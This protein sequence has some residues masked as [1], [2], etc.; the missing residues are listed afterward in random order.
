MVCD[1]PPTQDAIAHQNWN[2]YIKEYRRYAPDSMTILETRSV[3]KVQVTMT[4]VWYATLCHPKIYAHA[5][6]GIPTLINMRYAPDTNILKTMPE[7]K[8]TVTRK[9]YATLHHPRMNPHTKFGI[10]TS[11]I[12]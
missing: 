9:W 4:Q 7:V 5:K 1:T 3:V 10:S 6:F 8:A 2:S 11:K 12:I